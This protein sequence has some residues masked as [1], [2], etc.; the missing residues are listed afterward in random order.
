MM[1]YLDM[2][3]CEF[4]NQCEV[5]ERCPRALTPEIQDNAERWY[6]KPNPPFC[7]FMDKPKCF[8]EKE[9]LL[10]EDKK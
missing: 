3:F 7:L 8:Q 1:C 10:A 9:V 6:G 4:Y 2:T 5:G